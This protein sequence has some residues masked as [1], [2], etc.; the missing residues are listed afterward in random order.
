MR[1]ARRG[2]PLRARAPRRLVAAFRPPQRRE[3]VATRPRRRRHDAGIRPVERGAPA[4]RPRPQRALAPRSRGSRSRSISDHFHP[5]ID[6]QGESPFVWSVLGGIAL[7][8]E[9]LGVGTGVTC[10]TIRIHPA[11]VAQAAA[12]AARCCPAGSSSASAPARTSTSTC[13]ANVAVDRRAAARCSR[14][15]SRSCAS[16]GRASSPAIAGDHFTRRERPHLHAARRA[17]RGRWSPRRAG[18]RQLAGRIGDG[19]IGTAPDASRRGV[20][21]GRRRRQAALRAADGLLGRDRRRHGDGAEWW[22][23]AALRGPLGQELPL[24]SHFEAAV[25]DGHGGVD[26]GVDRLRPGS[27]GARRGDRRVRRRG[28][29]ARVSP[30]GWRGPGG[31]PALLRVGAPAPLQAVA[32]SAR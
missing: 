11:I 4:A 10:P 30:S 31:V 17:D 23:N 5:W 13:S 20:R 7:A 19:L 12:T 6:R 32:A 27:G 28:L 15:R 21:R 22:P 29:H 8:T 14:R 24:P 3:A 1:V 2:A 26:R 25:A 9:R 18:A 16:S